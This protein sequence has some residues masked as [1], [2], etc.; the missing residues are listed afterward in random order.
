MTMTSAATTTRQAAISRLTV[1]TSAIDQNGGHARRQH[2]PHQHVLDG[3]QRVGGGRHARGQ[4][5]GRRRG[6]VA[7]RMA[8][9]VAEEVAPDV[10]RDARRR[11]SCR[12][13]WRPATGRCRP[14][15]GPRARRSPA[16]PPRRC[17]PARQ[18]V[19]QQLH[20]VLRKDRADHRQSHC[21]KNDCVGFAVPPHVAQEECARADR[22]T[23]QGSPRSPSQ[24]PLTLPLAVQRAK[25]SFRFASCRI[26]RVR[27]A[28]SGIATSTVR[29]AHAAVMAS[30][31]KARDTA[32]LRCKIAGHGRAGGRA[33][34]GR[35]ADD[36]LRQIEAARAAA[37]CRPATRARARRA[38]P[39]SCHPASARR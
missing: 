25:P 6:E 39:R 10:A 13:S 8:G 26:C 19:D 7:R 37:R 23:S 5:A 11:S 34:A 31:A 32:E 18:R 38:R 21:T 36:A 20:G 33:D 17:A 22:Q 3:E 27:P 1:P 14:R 28:V 24:L 9:E 2:V 30:P 29:N 12:P 16:R 4:S 35:A 15:S